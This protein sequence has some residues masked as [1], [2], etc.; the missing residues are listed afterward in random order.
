VQVQGRRSQCGACGRHARADPAEPAG[1][2]PL[3][4]DVIGA[5][6]G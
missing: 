4:L 5:T 6:I 1:G 2:A 3:L